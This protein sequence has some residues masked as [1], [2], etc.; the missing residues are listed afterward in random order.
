MDEP[1]CSR[2]AKEVW[3]GGSFKMLVGF[4]GSEKGDSKAIGQ[5][6]VNLLSSLGVGEKCAVA[7]VCS[8]WNSVSLRRFPRLKNI[9]QTLY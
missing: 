7:A 5:K 4:G 3:G 6:A 1:K 2:I 9:F 8:L